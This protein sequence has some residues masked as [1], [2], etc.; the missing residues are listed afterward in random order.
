MCFCTLV[1]P[2][3]RQRQGAV[4]REGL[5]GRTVIWVPRATI[6]LRG[7]FHMQIPSQVP[8]LSPSPVSTV[9]SW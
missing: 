8:S 3:M 1:V 2:G 5:P 7:A 9:N 6:G 4:H